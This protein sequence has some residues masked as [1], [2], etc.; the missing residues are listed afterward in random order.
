VNIKAFPVKKL[1]LLF[2]ALLIVSTAFA[3]ETRVRIGNRDVTV[4]DEESSASPTACHA[5]L[6]EKI[7]K[8]GWHDEFYNAIDNGKAFFAFSQR[9]IE[10]G[11]CNKMKITFWKASQT[12]EGK[13]VTKSQIFVVT[14]AELSSFLDNEVRPLFVKFSHAQ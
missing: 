1:P 9:V 7:T 12:T 2:V 11:T 10:N 4:I 13:T 6:L 14:K 3:V 5:A 8:Q